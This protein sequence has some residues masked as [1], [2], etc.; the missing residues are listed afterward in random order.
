MH[1]KNVCQYKT[2][3]NERQIHSAFLKHTIVDIDYLV[4]S[5][6]KEKSNYNL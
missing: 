2:I 4:Y 3:K 5:E 1:N 6:R